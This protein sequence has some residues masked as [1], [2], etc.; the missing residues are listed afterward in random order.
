MD[1]TLHF[2][3]MARANFVAAMFCILFVVVPLQSVASSVAAVSDRDVMHH[4]ARHDWPAI[5]GVGR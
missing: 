2:N 5:T 3:R 1:L 4:A